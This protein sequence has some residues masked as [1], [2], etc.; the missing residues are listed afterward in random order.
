M[1]HSNSENCENSENVIYSI[2][3]DNILHPDA[4]INF[5]YAKTILNNNKQGI[6]QIKFGDK[7]MQYITKP[8][9]DV[10]YDVYPIQYFDGIR[11][12][13]YIIYNI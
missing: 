11:I 5:E 8:S 4:L 3:F 2:E 10:I 13:L 1:T 6:K 7:C 12:F 9:N